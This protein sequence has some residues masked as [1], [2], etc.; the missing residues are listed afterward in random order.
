MINYNINFNT[1]LVPAIIAFSSNYIF[2]SSSTKSESHQITT[3]SIPIDQI[4]N[5]LLDNI[6]TIKKD[7]KKCTN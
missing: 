5:F 7:N 6:I 1:L 4:K 3:R 2:N